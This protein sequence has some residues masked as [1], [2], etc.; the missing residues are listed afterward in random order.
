MYLAL[1]AHMTMSVNQSLSLLLSKNVFLYSC[2]CPSDEMFRTECNIPGDY[3]IIPLT[4]AF[5]TVSVY[6][7]YCPL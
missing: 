4:Q 3:T 7:A 1:S 5:V 2:K 6:E